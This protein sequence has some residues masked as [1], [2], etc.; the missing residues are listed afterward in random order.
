M[1]LNHDFNDPVLAFLI[2]WCAV[3]RFNVIRFLENEC[4]MIKCSSKELNTV[5]IF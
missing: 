5:Y 1:F 3:F 2:Y 4:V